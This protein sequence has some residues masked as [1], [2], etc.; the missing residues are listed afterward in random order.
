MEQSA[1]RTRRQPAFAWI[2]CGRASSCLASVRWVPRIGPRISSDVRNRLRRRLAFVVAAFRGDGYA[3]RAVTTQRVT[4]I[5]QKRL[6]FSMFGWTSR[7]QVVHDQSRITRLLSVNSIPQYTKEKSYAVSDKRGDHNQNNCDANFKWFD[8]VYRL[9]KMDP[10]YEIDD[11]LCP[12]NEYQRRTEDAM[13][14]RE[15]QAPI[16]PCLD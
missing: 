14:L 1:R 16:P 3:R 9:N 7:R 6:S 2:D 4:D 13:P 5:A 12:A 8:D 10:K 11:R 15:L